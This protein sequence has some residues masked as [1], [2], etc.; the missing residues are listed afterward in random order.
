MVQEFETT[1]EK[2]EQLGKG[3]VCPWKG[4]GTF[5]TP[6][7]A[8]DAVD[9]LME[10]LIREKT[11][12]VAEDDGMYPFHTA[13]KPPFTG[14][15]APRIRAGD[16]VEVSLEKELGFD[17]FVAPAGADVQVYVISQ[18]SWGKVTGLVQT[19]KGKHFWVHFE[20]NRTKRM[21]A[22]GCNWD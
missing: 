22:K 17:G 15:P 18:T 21:V 10:R 2:L 3:K 16:M 20:S 5:N 13:L 4:N 8:V 12:L 9:E 1:K 19:N 7:E 11:L 6:Q 14:V